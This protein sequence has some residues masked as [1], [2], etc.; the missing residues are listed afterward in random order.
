[1]ARAHFET[2]A[3][4]FSESENFSAALEHLQKATEHIYGIGHF[5]K[6]NDDLLN[7]QG[8][9]AVGQML[10]LVVRQITQLATKGRLN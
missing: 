1:M 8:W 4:Q 9:L 7:G 5:R 10:E 3:G 2:K 6:A